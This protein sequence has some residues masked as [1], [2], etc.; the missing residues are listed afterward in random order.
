MGTWFGVSL[1]DCNPL[2]LARQLKLRYMK[3]GQPKT[4]SGRPKSV[5]TVNEEDFKR[6]LIR[7]ITVDM[8]VNQLLQKKGIDKYC[9]GRT[10]SVY[11]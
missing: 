4:I 8:D 7:L 6:S 10:N 5:G 1:V 9:S 11:K 2:K 3:N